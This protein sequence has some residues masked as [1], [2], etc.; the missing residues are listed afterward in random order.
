M[1]LG[2]CLTPRAAVA[3]LAL[4]GDYRLAAQ[5]SAER[6]SITIVIGAEPTL[7]VPTL[8]N[9]QANVDVASL[10]FLRLARLGPAMS[11][12]DEKSFEPQLAR[13]WSRR[14]PLTLV[15]ELDPRARWHDGTPVSSRDVV[16]SLNRARDS[17]IAPTYALLLRRIGSVTAE[18]PS[19]VVVKFKLAYPEQLYDATWHAPP[20]PAHLLDSIP[21]DRLSSSAFV[22]QPVGN[23]PYRW[24]RF[25]PGQKLELVANREFFL[26]APRLDRIV[27]LLIRSAEAQLNAVQAGTADVFQGFLLARD[28]GPIVANPNLRIMT[29]PSYTVSYLLFNHRAYGDRSKPHPILADQEVRRALAMT[30]DRERLLRATFGP[31]AMVVNG[32]MGQASWIRRDGPKAP[33]YD[34]AAARALLGRKGWVD[35]DGDGVLDRDGTKLSLRL[36]Y[37][38]SSVPRAALAEPIQ[39]M[40]RAAGIDLQLARMEG[41]LWVERRNKG[42]FDIDFSQVTLDPTPSGLV[43]SWSCAGIGGSN[44]GGVCHPPFDSALARAVATPGSSVGPWHLALRNLQD[45]TP[46]LFLYSPAQI[47]VVSHRYRNVAFRPEA[48][49]TDLWRWSVGRDTGASRNER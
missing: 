37:P 18:G 21:P 17:T 7:P 14:D 6:A 9:F 25:E 27:F 41:A 47:A 33:G 44:V 46:A 48:P 12:I 1:R 8:S 19:R 31:Y 15:F 49:W 2:R 32:P 10:L 40:F 35:S 42:E 22:G 29:F 38:G 13:S 36:N 30:V 23:G 3:L 28:I 45:D 26:G 39:Q 34:P 20:L 43:Q 11:T 16:W 24:G 4:F 5:E